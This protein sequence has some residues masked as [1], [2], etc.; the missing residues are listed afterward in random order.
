MT[1]QHWGRTFDQVHLLRLKGNYKSIS[2][3]SQYSKAVYFN[4]SIMKLM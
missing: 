1:I 3:K 2:V 4:G